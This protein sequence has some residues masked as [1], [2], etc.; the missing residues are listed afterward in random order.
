MGVL[1]GLRDGDGDGEEEGSALLK[2]YGGREV[3]VVEIDG[4]GGE[5]VG[6]G[7]EVG[8][9]GQVRNRKKEVLKDLVFESERA[10]WDSLQDED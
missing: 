3:D 2:D 5:A 8:E 1:G 6:T 4:A 7:M 9:G 10:L